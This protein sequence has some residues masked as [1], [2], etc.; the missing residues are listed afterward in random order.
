MCEIL[1]HP[2][3]RLQIVPGNYEIHQAGQRNSAVR[4]CG[5]FVLR[6]EKFRNCGIATAFAE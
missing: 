2:I 4:A 3:L 1:H 5:V 6:I